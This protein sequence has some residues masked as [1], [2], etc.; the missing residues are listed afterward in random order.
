[1]VYTGVNAPSL[2]D[3]S[4]EIIAGAIRWGPGAMPAFPSSVLDDHQLDSVVTYIK[5]VQHPPAPGGRPLNW[6]GPVAEGIVAWVALF[7]IIAITG[8]IEK[9]GQG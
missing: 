1:M 4:P 9:G 7:A 6:Y 5:F 3:K 2:V 8:W